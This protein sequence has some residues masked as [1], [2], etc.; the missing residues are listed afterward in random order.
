MKLFCRNDHYII[1]GGQVILISKSKRQQKLMAQL[2]E[3]L[4][5][6][7][8][9][10]IYKEICDVPLLQNRTAIVKHGIDKAALQIQDRFANLVLKGKPKPQL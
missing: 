4:D 5:T 1:K 10:Q 8:R 7:I 9:Q 2:L 3:V 6:Q